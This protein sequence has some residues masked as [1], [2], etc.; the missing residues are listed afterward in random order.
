MASIIYF[1][2]REHE[3]GRHFLLNEALLLHFTVAVCY[4][5]DF[6]LWKE[7]WKDEAAQFFF[8]VNLKERSGAF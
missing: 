6:H 8:F 4:I 1:I 7:K 2:R 3:Q 5:T